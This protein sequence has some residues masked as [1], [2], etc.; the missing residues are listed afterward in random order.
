MVGPQQICV[1]NTILYKSLQIMFQDLDLEDNAG[2]AFMLPVVSRSVL[3]DSAM[4]L[5]KYKFK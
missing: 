1:L 2:R 5:F 4:V 3:S